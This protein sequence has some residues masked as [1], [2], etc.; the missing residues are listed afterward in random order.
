MFSKWS[1]AMGDFRFIISMCSK[2][3]V[4]TVKHWILRDLA[5]G[6]ESC[7]GG[8]DPKMS[9]VIRRDMRLERW[10]KHTQAVQPWSQTKLGME[11]QVTVLLQLIRVT[12]DNFSISFVKKEKILHCHGFGVHKAM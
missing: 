8:R 2:T 7:H 4:S 3:Q 9:K 5:A 10:Q 11:S 12:L 1:S 6:A